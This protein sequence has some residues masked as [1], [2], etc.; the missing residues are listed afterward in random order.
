VLQHCSD[1]LEAKRRSYDIL[2][3]D[4]AHSSAVLRD[5][6]TLLSKYRGRREVERGGPD[7]RETNLRMLSEKIHRSLQRTSCEIQCMQ[8]DMEVLSRFC[9]SGVIPPAYDSYNV[10]QEDV[11]KIV[12]HRQDAKTAE[13]PQKGKVI[14]PQLQLGLLPKEHARLG[15]PTAELRAELPSCGSS[16]SSGSDAAGDEEALGTWEVQHG[17]TT[18]DHIAAALTREVVVPQLQLDRL[19]Q[20]H[21]QLQPMPDL[22][23]GSRSSSSFDSSIASPMAGVTGVVGASLQSKGCSIEARPV[24]SSSHSVPY[25]IAPPPQVLQQKQQC[26]GRP[27]SMAA[28]PMAVTPPVPLPVLTTESGVQQT[29]II[30]CV[31][32]LAAASRGL[33]NAQGGSLNQG[34]RKSHSTTALR[35]VAIRQGSQLVQQQQGSAAAPGFASPALGPR[36]HSRGGGISPLRCASSATPSRPGPA[37]NAAPRPRQKASQP[38]SRL[39]PPIQNAIGWQGRCLG[40]KHSSPSPE[41]QR[42]A[43]A[44][45]PLRATSAPYAKQVGLQPSGSTP[46]LP[47]AGRLQ[48]APT[49]AAGV[50]AEVSVATGAT[51]TA[52][53]PTLGAP[54]AKSGWSSP[55]PP[56][57]GAIPAGGSSVQQA[58][59]ACYQRLEIAAAP[60]TSP[61]WQKR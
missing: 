56:P 9:G 52:V 37:T 40:A 25:L 28:L 16:E 3:A 33:V 59:A 50:A 8:E 32:P 61:T 44:A 1:L 42:V 38:N 18:A 11:D 34:V 55:L 5:V 15:P 7:E 24:L 14:V 51:A 57:P 12:Q 21:P 26:L 22:D 10:K 31:S 29:A 35:S 17:Q 47:G 41:R 4:H 53:A 30:R 13:A 20:E 58:P 2:R 39:S 19:P 6:D 49:W 48:S 27:A 46:C 23:T 43:A 60:H 54:C 45:S 36:E